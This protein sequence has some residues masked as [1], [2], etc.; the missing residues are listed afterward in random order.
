MPANT[1]PQSATETLAN[2]VST[3][4]IDIL[5]V[6][7]GFRASVIH[8]L[9]DLE[10]VLIAQLENDNL[11]VNKSAKLSALLSQSQKQISNAYSLVSG[12]MQENLKEL[13]T[14]EKKHTEASVAKA[15]NV[16]ASLVSSGLS[17]KQLEAVVNKP[18]LFGHS[19]AD[20]WQGQSEELRRKFS[21]AMQQ[22]FLLGESV[23]ELARRI[24]GSKDHG[25]A[26]GIMPLTKRQAEALVRSSVIAI[27]NQASIETIAEMGDIVKGIQWSCFVAGTMVE[28]PHKCTPI[29]SIQPGDMVTGGSG[30]P[31]KV[32]AVS[33][34]RRRL[35]ARL[36]LSNGETLTCTADHRFL[37]LRGWVQARHLQNGEPFAF[38]Q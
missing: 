12:M 10:G 13:A 37:T 18:L 36:K 31:R 6:G 5:R 35:M 1:D 14:L 20:W 22:G 4:T 28:Q 8:T 34:N 21:G 32:I 15:M 38:R 26:D 29:E 24:R 9:S 27:S 19:S 11:S 33:Q 2:G 17:A 16:S 25:Y 23:D 7:A 3:H 30:L